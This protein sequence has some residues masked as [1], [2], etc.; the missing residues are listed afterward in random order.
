MPPVPLLALASL[1]DAGS[2]AQARRLYDA[3]QEPRTLA[4][5]PARSAAVG[6]ITG[7]EPSELKSV[8]LEFL[9]SAFEP[10]SALRRRG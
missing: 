9:R 1:T 4:L 5:Y 8:L 3:A 7:D 6:L 10:L 2:S